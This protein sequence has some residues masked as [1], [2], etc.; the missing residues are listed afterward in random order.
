MA[1]KNIM[2]TKNNADH[3]LIVE[4][5][6]TQAEQ[7]KH[8]LEMHH[9]KVMVA[10]NGKEALKM[11]FKYKPSLVISDII[12]LEMDGYKLCKKLKSN[13]STM[14]IPI[15]LLTALS[16]SEDAI[17]G[18]ACGADHFIIKPYIED[19]LISLIKHIL[20]KTK[21][22]KR[23]NVKVG[24]ELEIGGKKRFITASQ[25]QMLSLLVSTYKAAVDKNNELVLAQDEL[26]KFNEHLEDMVK[27]RTLELSRINTEKDQFFSIIAHDLRSPISGLIGLTEM[28]IRNA[29]SI[30]QD[31]LTIIARRL[32]DSANNLYQLLENL[33]KWTEIQ[34]N[35]ICF[36][37]QD[38]NLSALIQQNIKVI[39][40]RALQK[41]ISIVN[42]VPV[43]QWIFADEKMINTILRNLLSNAVKFTKSGGSVAIR[44]KNSD[45]DMIEISVTDSG[46]GMAED[47]I[48]MLFR[49]N[50]KVGS[51]GTDGEASAG[52]GLI[53]CNEFVKMHGGKIWA[54][55][56]VNKGSIFTFTLKKGSSE[57]NVNGIFSVK[58]KSNRLEKM[59]E[60]DYEK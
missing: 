59:R 12:M 45:S 46:V 6:P 2:N 7:L 34:K 33:L 30:P 39:E 14:D 4:D 17:K 60:D 55:S 32:N 1:M 48:K 58:N 52:L 20:A 3:I 22:H 57:K 26:N 25:Q 53:L 50:E 41:W 16:G 28:M 29:L 56:E 42:E 8:I 24:V 19:Y 10:K 54:H 15:I 23:E 44:C 9:Y 27:E 43:D 49:I 51:A 40:E 21:I 11:V 38:L 47:T 37:P 18:L 5:S 13:Q 35:S 31:E 36:S